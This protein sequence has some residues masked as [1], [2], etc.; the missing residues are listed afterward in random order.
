MVINNQTVRERLEPDELIEFRHED[1]IQD[2][3]AGLAKLCEFT[4]LEPETEYLEACSA[5][6]NPAPSRKREQVEWDSGVFSHVNLMIRDY[7]F[8]NTY[9]FDD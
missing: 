8:L 9:S 1:F 3:K 6:V 7:S 4:G 5:I 2:P